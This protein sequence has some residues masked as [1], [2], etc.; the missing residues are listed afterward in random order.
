MYNTYADRLLP[1]TSATEEAADRLIM[2][3][4]IR[5]VVCQLIKLSKERMAATAPEA[6]VYLSTKGVHIRSQKCKH[7][8]DQ[9]LGPLKVICKV[10]FNS[11]KL[12][13]P[14]GYR[15]NSMFHC[16]MLSHASSSTSSPRPH[17]A[18]IEGDH[19]KYGVDYISDV[20][21]DNWPRRRG[22]Y[23]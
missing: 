13:L 14:N 17:Q 11:Y 19:E 5:D 4:N 10:G 7:L 21:I 1:L 15:L 23:L 9:R 20:K 12:L 2:I 16:D 6:H 8:R 3:T 22:P 18:E